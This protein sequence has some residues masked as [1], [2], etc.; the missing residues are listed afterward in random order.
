[1]RAA[2]DTFAARE[3]IT[4]EQ[5][6]AG[7][8][9]TARKLT[10]LHR[11]PD[12]V[13]VADHEV[14]PMLL[15]PSHT[16][17]YAQFARNRMV[18]AYTDQSRGANEITASNWWQIV[19]RPG[20][21]VGR[22]EPSLDPNGYRTLLVWQLAERFYREPRL[23]ERLAASAPRRNVRPMEAALVALLQ[24]GELDYIWSYESIAEAANLRYIRLPAEI[25]LSAVEHSGAYASASVRISGKTPRESTTVRGEPIV[26]GF[27]IPKGAPHPKL[28]LR[29]ASF[30][31]SVDGR[32]V[33]RAAKLDAL[34]RPLFVGS[35][36]PSGV[37]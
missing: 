28:A 20:V 30:L 5:E 25:D 4:V 6:S 1:M 33:L 21:Q 34:E 11:T 29:F 27:T 19:T 9:E 7:S 3:S 8:I 16:S 26:Y 36:V 35:D 2:L 24:A 13:A 15:M 31:L 12:I 14:I 17:W 32:R 23:G 22:A 18:V 10:E 37:R